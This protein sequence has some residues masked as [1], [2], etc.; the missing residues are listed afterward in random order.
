M[1]LKKLGL[2]MWIWIFYFVHL[3]CK[4]QRLKLFL[5]GLEDKLPKVILLG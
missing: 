2:E 3:E 1:L 5:L 4:N